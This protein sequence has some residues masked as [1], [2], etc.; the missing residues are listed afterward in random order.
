M[1]V[2]QKLKK[3]TQCIL[4]LPLHVG[5]DCF[6]KAKV[7]TIQKFFFFFLILHIKLSIL[8]LFL[9]N[10]IVSIQFYSTSRS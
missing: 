1:F 4:L 2:I 5:G 8:L 9:Y 6:S 3:P 7:F 10:I